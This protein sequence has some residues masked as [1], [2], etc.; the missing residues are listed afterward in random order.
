MTIINTELLENTISDIYQKHMAKD[1]DI[2]D[3]DSF[4]KL[5]H[6]QHGLEGLS[7]ACCEWQEFYNFLAKEYNISDKKYLELIETFDKMGK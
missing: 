4:E 6:I 7:L 5:Y 1:L 3:P 2:E